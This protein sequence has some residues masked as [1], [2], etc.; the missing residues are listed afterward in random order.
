MKQRQQADH[1]A[2]TLR[3]SRRSSVCSSRPVPVL[4]LEPPA[5]QLGAWPSLRK[6]E[7]KAWQGG[8]LSLYKLLLTGSDAKHDAHI[9]SVDLCKEVGLPSPAQLLH[10]ERARLL[11]PHPNRI[12]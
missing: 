1:F 2:S 4:S 5:A 7:A 8:V 10:L 12:L 6:G 11:G 9:S 3:Q